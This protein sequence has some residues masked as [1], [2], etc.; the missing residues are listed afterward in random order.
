MTE[1]FR[2]I[3]ADPPWPYKRKWNNGA[4]AA[5]NFSGRA[6][7]L[8]MP[9]EEM[10]VS[11]IAALPVAS[12]V[13]SDGAH[14]YLWTTNKFLHDAFHVAE[15]W[16]FHYSQLLVWAKT[17][18]GKGLGGAFAQTAEYILFCRD[19]LP[20]TNERL[21]SVWFNWKRTSVHSRK[22]PESLDLV[23]QVSPGPYVELFARDARLGWERW[24]N[25][26]GSTIE[27]GAVAPLAEER[28]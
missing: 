11:E 7:A 25:E 18:G 15:A 13:H 28:S 17:P 26:A 5:K 19:R 10:E 23:E 21:N 20:I 2:T 24:G 4:N 22:P 16:G 14:L 8:P 27:L 1:K 6:G 12:L 3:V 9:Y